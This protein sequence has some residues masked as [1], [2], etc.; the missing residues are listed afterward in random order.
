MLKRLVLACG[1][2]M[3][4]GCNFSLGSC[5]PLTSQPANPQKLGV[6][7]Q[8]DAEDEVNEAEIAM[9]YLESIGVT[10]ARA[11]LSWARIQPTRNSL[12][13]QGPDAL[14]AAAKKHAVKLQFVLQDTPTWASSAPAV[15]STR[16]TYPPTNI[17]D[18]YRFVLVVAGRYGADVHDWEVWD[19]IDSRVGWT[20]R[21]EDYARLVVIAGKAIKGLNPASRVVLGS[22]GFGP[23]RES[24]FLDSVLQDGANPVLKTVD[25]V[26]LHP[27]AVSPSEARERYFALRRSL[28]RQSSVKPI[29]ITGVSW[30]SDGARQQGCAGYAGGE[31]GQARY[32]RETLPWLLDLG[33]DR[34]FWEYLWD[35]V[36]DGPSGS[37]G[38]FDRQ[39]Q[40]K[41]ALGALA[42]LIDPNRVGKGVDAAS[43]AG[44]SPSPTAR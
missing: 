41:A 12:N 24:Q 44:A 36:P 3:A 30:S 37:L 32:L 39:I 19:S 16:G 15:S 40:P 6:G 23:D 34:V 10:L 14:V 4:S 9:T 7:I 42:G 43:D 25:A 13:W 38:L 2:L 8:L 28:A 18:W 27:G 20:G 29:L 17:E 33:A 22:V 26:G 21:A 1:L 11:P 31:P 5:L 35:G